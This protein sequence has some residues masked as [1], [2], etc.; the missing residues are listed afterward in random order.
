LYNLIFVDDEDIVREGIKSRVNWGT[1]G[2]RLAGVFEN[3]TEAFEFLKENNVDVV[4]S[5]ISMPKMDGITLSKK[6]SETFPSVQV[7][8]LTGFEEF[9]Y[10]REAL[11]NRVKEFL[12]KPITADE[13]SDVLER[14]KKE[15]DRQKQREKE[16]AKLL[17][18]LER[19]LPLLKERFFYSLVSGRLKPSE[20]FRRAKL[21]GWE[22]LK[23]YYQS[24]IVAFPE[25]WE[26]ISR[27]ALAEHTRSLTEQFDEVF[28]NR[29]EDMVILMQGNTPEELDKR[30]RKISS[31]I[32][33]Y[34]LKL[35]D[36]PVTIGSGEAVNRLNDINRSYLG[37]THAVDYSKVMGVTR[38]LSIDEIRGKSRVSQEAFVSRAKNL[39]KVLREGAGKTAEE[40]LEDIFMLFKESYLTSSDVVTFLARLHY[41]L[42][43]FVDEMNLNDNSDLDNLNLSADIPVFTKLDTAFDYYKKQIDLI[44]NVIHKRRKDAVLSRIDKAK[45]IIAERYN[46]KNFSLQDICAEIYLSSSQFSALFKEGTG[47]TFIE[48]L[49]GYRINEAKK[50][51]KTTDLKTY[52]IAEKVGYQDP[53]YFSS[54]FK[55]ETGLT[56]TE[57]RREIEKS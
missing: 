45:R 1:N 50:L 16:N 37:A 27:L 49:T 28:T 9:E 20:I 54:I 57:Y 3:G 35:G 42:S 21:F 6:I 47:Q 41:Y 8:L 52:E 11:R 26:E 10:A 48:Y 18:L 33:I 55:K 53:G 25:D 24:A 4:L 5:D 23:K 31:S 36:S 32:F 22:D 7:L 44:E 13:I 30:Y 17:E 15:L 43:D 19:S 56:T 12:L 34:A 38:I 2:F 46:D 14:V 39:I 51:L 29:N 40:A